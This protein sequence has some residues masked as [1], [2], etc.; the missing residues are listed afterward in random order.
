MNRAEVVTAIR[1]IAH[2][3]KLGGTLSY[4]VWRGIFN[5]QDTLVDVT[6]GD[7]L[8]VIYCYALL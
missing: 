5:M 8:T 7:E 1:D 2:D 6:V 3:K 4:K